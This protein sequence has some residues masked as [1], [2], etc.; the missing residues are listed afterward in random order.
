MHHCIT[1]ARHTL[2]FEFSEEEAAALQGA[3]HPLVRRLPRS[4]RRSLYLASHTSHILHWPVPE[5]RLLIRDLMEHATQPQF[6]FRHSWRPGDFVIWDNRATLHRA[7]RFDDT[8]YKRE[9][10]CVATLD[11]LAPVVV[12]ASQHVQAATAVK[13]QSAR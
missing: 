5:S 6:V 13:I 2:G 1:Y 10:R 4:A 7:L 9:L 12:Y 8:N 3:L 11:I